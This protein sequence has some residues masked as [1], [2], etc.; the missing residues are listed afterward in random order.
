[1]GSS[2]WPASTSATS[3]QPTTN[4]PS[5]GSPLRSFPRSP[6]PPP[7][8]ASSSP[9][10]PSL[11][12]LARSSSSRSHPGFSSPAN[13]ASAS[14]PSANT[15]PPSGPNPGSLLSTPSTTRSRNLLPFGHAPRPLSQPSSNSSQR[16]L[17]TTP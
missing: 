12:R 2:P 17:P 16:S 3:L 11:S 13:T 7:P 4:A 9:S 5:L 10:A 15:S 8:H 6:P 14:S 1:M